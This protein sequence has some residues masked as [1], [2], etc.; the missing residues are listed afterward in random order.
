MHEYITPV[1]A[2]V[3]GVSVAFIA[4]SGG[5]LRAVGHGLQSTVFAAISNISYR[6]KVILSGVLV[7]GT[8]REPLEEAAQLLLPMR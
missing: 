4:V 7:V 8:K 6:F 1:A 5:S 3:V 2:I